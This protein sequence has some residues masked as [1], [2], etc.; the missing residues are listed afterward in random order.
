MSFGW[1]TKIKMSNNIKAIQKS[2]FAKFSNIAKLSDVERD[3][4]SISLSEDE[5]KQLEN[6]VKIILSH[7]ITPE[8]IFA[9]T[10][11][12]EKK[13]LLVTGDFADF[14]LD[15]CA[16]VDDNVPMFMFAI[17]QL[18]IPCKR[19]VSEEL[20]LEKIFTGENNR[21]EW[22]NVACFFPRMCLYE[23]KDPWIDGN[24]EDCEYYLRS[25]MVAVCCLNQQNLS[26]PFEKETISEYE[27]LLNRDDKHI[28]IDN[29]LHSL[30]EGEWKFCF[31]DVY[32]TI[33]RLFYVSWIH[34][35]QIEFG[36]T[37][38]IPEINE[39]LRKLS[40]EH[41]ED[42][43]MIH[44]FSCVNGEKIGTISSIVGNENV[45]K[46][47]YRLR[48]EIVHFQKS[49]NRINNIDSKCWNQLIRFMIMSIIDLYAL[50]N[51][52]I[53]ELPNM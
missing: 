6:G 23:L 16:E 17:S 38:P 32:R 10:M 45:G 42:K 26:L 28:P 21:L 34:K 43:C 31:L 47:I 4:S 7:K 35:C 1:H 36:S 5:F 53:D 46:Y 27:N 20:L 8:N 41:H 24:D 25:L 13:Y 2:I 52:Y 50:L 30:L 12:E 11:I 22:Q 18:N 49:D 15:A 19:N 40:V 33:E 3:K 14:H 44:L 48:N 29:I 9:F 39:S 37:K 51:K